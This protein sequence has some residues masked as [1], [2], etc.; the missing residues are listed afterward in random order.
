MNRDHVEWREQGRG[1]VN[2]ML[3]EMHRISAVRAAAR[4]SDP[5]KCSECGYELGNLSFPATCDYCGRVLA[6][7]A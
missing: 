4:C 6:P 7:E 3:R 1:R 2:D 5:G